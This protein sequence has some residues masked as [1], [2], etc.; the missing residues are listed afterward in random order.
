[1]T[2]TTSQ[3]PTVSIITVSFNSAATIRDTIESVLSQDYPHVQYIVV[4]GGSKDGT[5]ELVQSYRSRLGAFV[6]ER[7]RGMYDAMN[8]GIS[9]ATGDIVGILNSD[10]VY[11]DRHVITDLVR[12]MREKNSDSAF[13]DLI[14]VDRD[15]LSRVRRYYDSGGW[16]PQRFRFGWMPAHPTFILKRSCYQAHG[17]FSLDF[18]TAADYELLVRMLYRA[19]TTY[20]YL[21]RPA[22]K[23]RVGGAST[24][25]L[26]QVWRHNLQVVRSCK[27]NG[28]WTSLPLVLLKTPAKLLGVLRG[29]RYV[30]SEAKRVV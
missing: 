1:M 20:A 25:G 14:Y 24:Q 9:M 15:D 12:V 22:I 21:A 26:R 3:Q 17:L 18:G 10:D 5:V 2:S 4:D 28:M 7:D 16:N 13:A 8:K 11:A 27:A 6:S 23:M 19:R 30:P 29:R